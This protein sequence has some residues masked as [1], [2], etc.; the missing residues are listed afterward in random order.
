MATHSN[1]ISDMPRPYI[2]CPSSVDVE[3]PSR[4]RTVR[5]SFPQP[6]SNVD[7]WRY[8]SFVPFFFSL[9]RHF[10][11]VVYLLRSE[12]TMTLLAT[13]FFSLVKW[14]Q[15]YRLLSYTLYTRYKFQTRLNPFKS[16]ICQS[17]DS[18]SSD[19]LPT[20]LYESFYIPIFNQFLY[21]GM[22]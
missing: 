10:Y 7:W 17:P 2:R 5:V 11:F 6:K 9:S 16:S 22:K 4:Q 19:C 13:F 14:I 3:L 8:F 20:K 18:I 12:F 1:L 15:V 21:I